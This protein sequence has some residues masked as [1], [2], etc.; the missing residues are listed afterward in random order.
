MGN[1]R[2]ITLWPWLLLGPQRSIFDRFRQIGARSAAQALY[3]AIRNG[4]WQDFVEK[5]RLNQVYCVRRP[6]VNDILETIGGDPEIYSFFTSG[7]FIRRLGN[8]IFSIMSQPTVFRGLET[9]RTCKIPVWVFSLIKH[10]VLCCI[11]RSNHKH[12]PNLKTF[13]FFTNITIT[14]CILSPVIVMVKKISY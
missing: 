9:P 8:S 1:H 7:E 4:Y 3:S 6:H 14:K 10:E 13:S 12:Y 2:T 5:T 11:L